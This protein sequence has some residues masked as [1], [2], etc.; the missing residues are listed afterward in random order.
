MYILVKNR[1]HDGLSVHGITANPFVV[2]V[3]LAGSSC[4]GNSFLDVPFGVTEEFGF[5]PLTMLPKET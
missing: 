3:W 1:G 5:K 4:E 2:G